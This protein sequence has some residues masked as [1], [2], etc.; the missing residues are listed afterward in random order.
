MRGERDFIL[1]QVISGDTERQHS[2]RGKP[3][4]HTA[5]PLLSVKFYLADNEIM[6]CSLL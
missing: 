3:V 5:K 1:L 2:G 4:G 6:K